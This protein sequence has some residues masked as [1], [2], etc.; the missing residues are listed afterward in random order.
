MKSDRILLFLIFCLV[1][2]GCGFQAADDAD[3]E[4]ELVLVEDDDAED[5]DDDMDDDTDDDNADDDIDD[6]VDDD[7]D[8]DADDDVCDHD[9]HDPLIE[10]GKDL[11]TALEPQDAYGDFRTALVA[12]PGS[13]D[14]RYG[15]LLADAQWYMT[16]ARRWLDYLLDFNPAPHKSAEKSVGSTLQKVIEYQLLPVNDEMRALAGELA[17]NHPDARFVLESF[18]VWTED[19][20]VTLDFAGEWDGADVG[21][22]R[23]FADAWEFIGRA[24]IAFDLTFDWT[25][26]AL[27][28][29]PEGAP[30]EEVIHHYMGIL[31]AILDDPDYPDFLTFLPGGEESLETAALSAG[32][33]FRGLA[34]SFL[35]SR[36]I[37][38]D[39]TDD[40][41]GYVDENG[42]GRWNRGEN[43]RVPGAGDQSDEWS[44]SVD[45]ML[46]M[47]E[48]LGIAFWDEGPSDVRTWWPDW[49]VL[50]HLNWLMDLPDSGGPTLV[51]PPIPLPVGPLFYD[52]PADG[53][54]GTVRTIAEFLY[55][56]TA[57]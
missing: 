26:F 52:P 22:L 11:L 57:P 33:A 56:V 20:A 44:A 35:A 55:E 54:R 17:E 53:L 9:V 34:S 12:C 45:E 40:V 51:L 4:G 3:G 29:A 32:A 8:D 46:G 21:L 36:N 1:F 13:A 48:N 5:D 31:I 18:P 50:S 37:G 30:V 43:W 2:A 38:G 49:F 42:N 28:P 23:A 6:D 7:G 25:L 14:A 27:D 16:W 19:D 39:Q 10:S 24:L 15:L 41:L 47:A